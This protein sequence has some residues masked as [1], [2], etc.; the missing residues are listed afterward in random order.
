MPAVPVLR[1][2]AAGFLAGAALLAVAAAAMA[3][4]GPDDPRLVQRMEQLCRAQA[5]AAGGIDANV[6]KFCRCAAPVL[7]RHLTPAARESF[8]LQNRA[9]DGPAYEDDNAVLEAVVAACPPAKAP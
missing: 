3:E 6:T 2:T 4:V 5:L 7:A 8:V 9:P 1:R